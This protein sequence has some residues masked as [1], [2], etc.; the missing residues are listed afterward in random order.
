VRR[1]LQL[2][3][4]SALRSRVGVAVIL[5][6]VVFGVIGVARAVSGPG[7]GSDVYSGGA[8]ERPVS[9][10]DPTAGDDGVV[11][12][13]PGTDPTAEP[14]VTVQ[15]G[16]PAPLAVAKA[17]ASAWLDRE[18]TPERW[19]AGL[20]PH[21]TAD[22]AK[23]L[24]GV[25]PSGVPAERMTGPASVIPRGEQFLE[26]VYPLDVGNLRLR[27]VAP[28]GRWLVDGVDWERP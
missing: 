15:P 17:F 20:L 19:Y 28:D 13:A 16:T 1:V 8:P 4:T 26:V 11:E 22:L 18:A 6:V 25:D 7:A 5:L 24:E 9:T 23:R 12:S 10:V 21:S 3:A 14:V 27:L 2:V